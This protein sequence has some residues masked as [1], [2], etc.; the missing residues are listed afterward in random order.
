MPMRTLYH[1]K[2]QLR[3]C[4]LHCLNAVMQGPVFSQS[5]LWAMASDLD[6]GRATS[7]SLESISDNFSHNVSQHGD[8]S[9]QV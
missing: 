5:D 9:I 7:D 4:G 2:Q 8:F 3:L 6:R 1:E